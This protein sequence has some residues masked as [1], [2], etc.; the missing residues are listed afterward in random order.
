E[1]CFRDATDPVGAW[2]SPTDWLNQVR[3]I[4]AVQGRGKLALCMTKLWTPANTAQRH[5]WRTFTLASYLLARGS[6][7]YYMFMGCRGQRALSSWNTNWPNIGR[8]TGAR[9][10]IGSI[11]ERPFSGGMVAVN[12][13]GTTHSIALHATYLTPSGQAVTSLQLAPHSGTVL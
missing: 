4:A 8:A 3:A 11:W 5:H 7:G 12:P 13:S 9:S 6:A 2:P 1:G 10:Q